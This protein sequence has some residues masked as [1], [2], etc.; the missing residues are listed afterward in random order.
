[1][2]DNKQGEYKC[3]ITCIMPV[4]NAGRF[5]S[6]T[7]EMVIN[8]T[9]KD[10]ELIIIDDGST[11]DSLSVAREY[12]SLDNR[13]R[14][15]RMDAPSG[16][17][18]QPRK[19]GI[20]AA[21]GEIIA[22]V[23]ADD[24]IEKDY[25]GKL[26]E[27]KEATGANI[28]YPSIWRLMPDGGTAL[29]APKEKQFFEREFEGRDCVKYTLDGWRIN[30]GG[31]LIEK[32]LYIDAFEKFGSDDRYT[33][34]DEMLSRQML[35]ITPKVAFSDV[36]YFYRLNH[37]SVTQKKC[38]S[39]FDFDIS[40]LKLLE[41]TKRTF[42]SDSEEY[43]LANRQTFHGIFD[44]LRILNKNKFTPSDRE[45]IYKLL[46]DLKKRVDIGLIKDCVS[47]RYRWLFGRK[48]KTIQRVLRIVDAIKPEP[49]AG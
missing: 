28:V 36:K 30:C 15:L 37:E 13:I 14:V 5:L 6:Q 3:K 39:I 35:S 21:R 48:M 31:G 44:S 41:F 47:P 19:A 25:L 16:S 20:M 24:V 34:A 22:P 17:A 43:R 32:S 4:Y 10:F 29:L 26:L 2:T 9:F 45:K 1:M 18:F 33:R 49:S 46:G 23:D 40:N 8:Q 42:G 12:E 27:K 7:I 11:D 38:L